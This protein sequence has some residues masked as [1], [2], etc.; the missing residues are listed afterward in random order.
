MPRRRL[1]S[2]RYCARNIYFELLVVPD[3]MHEAAVHRRM[4]EMYERT[5]DFLHRFVW[6]KQ[7]P[8]STR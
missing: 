4:L 1:G 3:D 6:L 2:F 7:T 5:A 8:P